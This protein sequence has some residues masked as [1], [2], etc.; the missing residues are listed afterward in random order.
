M[1]DLN[2]RIKFWRRQFEQSSYFSREEI[3]E[4]ESHFRDLIDRE[5]E[6][7]SDPETAFLTAKAAL[8]GVDRLKSEYSKA[9]PGQFVRLVKR[10][11]LGFWAESSVCDD[12]F[13]RFSFLTARAVSVLIWSPLL[14]AYYLLIEGFI[15]SGFARLQLVPNGWIMMI[16]ITFL[17]VVSAMHFD[18]EFWGAKRHVRLV[19]LL[20]SA[21]WLIWLVLVYSGNVYQNLNLAIGLEELSWVLQLGLAPLLWVIY[22]GEIRKG[23]VPDSV[24]ENALAVT[25]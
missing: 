25:N 15:G 7:G 5:I 4:L 23:K 16:D 10:V 13:N 20:N 19:W 3:D 14:W 21:G 22:A 1:F 2:S 9:N 11:G 8:G 24:E 18:F 12:A 17:A 6:L